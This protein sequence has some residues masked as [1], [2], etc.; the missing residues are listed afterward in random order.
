M[1]ELTEKERE[2]IEH[3]LDKRCG[4]NWTM[5]TVDALAALMLAVQE[6]DIETCVRTGS[7]LAAYRIKTSTYGKLFKV[8]P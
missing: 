1:R 5:T 8:K 7:H 4:D 2:M 3:F 6:A